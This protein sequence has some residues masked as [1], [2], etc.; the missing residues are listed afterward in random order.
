MYLGEMKTAEIFFSNKV[1]NLKIPQ[2]LNCTKNE[3]F[4]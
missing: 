3:V 4:H 1:K 2:Y